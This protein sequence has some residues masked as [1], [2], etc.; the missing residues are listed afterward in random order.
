MALIYIVED[1]PSIQEV[2][3]IAL[4]TNNHMVNVFDCA[5]TFYKKLEDVLPDLILLDVMLP[6]QDGYQVLRYLHSN[7]K[8]RRIPVIMVTAKTSEMDMVKGLDGGADDYIRKPFSIMELLSRVR[9][10]LRR[11]RAEEPSQLSVGEITLDHDRHLVTVQGRSVELTLKEYEFLRYLMCNEN[12]VLSRDAI[13][14]YVWG[15]DFEG[16]SRTVDVHIKTLRQKLG[17]A[18]RQIRTVRGVGYAIGAECS[19]ET[20]AEE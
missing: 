13:M 11:S 10:L 8:T 5:D 16:N 14:Q 7:S 15:T 18:G 9:A 4:K 2:E 20:G 1:D 17:E 6:D 3:S 12:I 19:G